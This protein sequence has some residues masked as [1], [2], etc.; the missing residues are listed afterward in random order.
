[1]LDLAK[2]KLGE[3]CLLFKKEHPRHLLNVIEP[4]IYVQTSPI[5]LIITSPLKII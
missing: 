1:M 4:W 3:L 5:I 2:L